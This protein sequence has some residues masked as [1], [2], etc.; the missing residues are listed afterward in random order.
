MCSLRHVLSA[1]YMYCLRSHLHF[2]FI[3][4]CRLLS[5]L[6]SSLRGGVDPVGFCV[7]K[8]TASWVGLGPSGF[9]CPCVLCWSC[10]CVPFC[11]GLCGPVW[12]LLGFVWVGLC[13][14]CVRAFGAFNLALAC[15]NVP[16][17]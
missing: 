3:L 8:P 11:C 9:G 15:Y 16:K 10:G 13:S 14:V 1:S 6:L 2:M 17:M 4:F 12:A 5:R 7:L